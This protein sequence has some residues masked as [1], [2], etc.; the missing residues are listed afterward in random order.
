MVCW[1]AI[2]NLSIFL[3]ESGR[4]LWDG[5]IYIIRIVLEGTFSFLSDQGSDF[6]RCVSRMTFNK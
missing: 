4:E 1:E 6:D 2:E 3:C 5:I